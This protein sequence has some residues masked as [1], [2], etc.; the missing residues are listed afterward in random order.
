MRAVTRPYLLARLDISQSD[1]RKVRRTADLFDLGIL[2]V[3]L[4]AVYLAGR[5]VDAADMGAMVLAIDV[6][7]GF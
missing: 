5:K 6:F 1:K 2:K 4:D 3:G 7:V